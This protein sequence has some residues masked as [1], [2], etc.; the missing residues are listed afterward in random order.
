MNEQKSALLRVTVAGILSIFTFRLFFLQI[1][2]GNQYRILAE[3][4]RFQIFH[5]QAPRGLILDAM[6]IP[7]AANASAFNMY[8][9]PHVV[10]GEIQARV[11]RV[12][13]ILGMNVDDLK[14]GVREAKVKNKTTQIAHQLKREQAIRFFETSREYP[15][16]FVD[17]ESL[18]YYP[19][20]ETF[21]HILGYL[22]RIQSREEY[23]QL[24]AKGYRFDSW[25]GRYGLEKAFE[26]NLR[27]L[28]GAVLI[29]VDVRGRPIRGSAQRSTSLTHDAFPGHDVVLTVRTPLLKAAYEALKAS[30]S[31]VGSAVA[32]DP[33]TGAV[34]A[35]VTTPGFDPN[36]YV[37]LDNPV[38]LARAEFTRAL[39]GTYPPGSVFKIVTSAAALEAGM[40]AN[41]KFNCPGFYSLP[42]RVFKCWKEGGHGMC[43]FV[44][45]LKN[46]CDVYYYNVGLFAGGE[47]ISAQAS[48]FGLGSPI[49]IEEFPQMGASG[50]IPSPSWKERKKG[51]IWRPGDTLNL[52]IGQG[53]VLTTPLQL[54]ALLSLTANR[55]VVY[56]PYLVS[57]IR[58][59]ASGA[60]I[61]QRDKDLNHSVHHR[62]QGIT[63]KSWN[64]IEEGLRQVVES[65]TARGMFIPG[66]AIFGK[67]GTA[68][69]PHG[70]DHALFVCY[71]KDAKGTPRIAIAV[72]VENSG[73]GGSA[74][75]PVARKIVEAFIKDETDI[76]TN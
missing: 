30:K 73:H 9:N 57:E 22:T 37:R 38:G 63:D 33:R 17:Y 44:A 26:D 6:G 51:D 23:K 2:F 68:Q 69:N 31:G 39:T 13:A 20:E 45:G 71:I 55:G 66:V 76:I 41:R 27:G 46:S 32:L 49:Y 12:A 25:I 24:S 52:S 62:T 75:V 48:N 74:A 47:K 61:Y 50:F 7:L 1:V 43:D 16:F 54:A 60:A 65:G 53:E 29:E 58:D 36:K 5:R 11:E 8:F 72:V 64:L 15:E 42:T 3:R 70:D 35:L 56:K 28:D 21:S 19:L 10:A 18:R 14:K 34:L 40:D 4:N 67:T 59:P